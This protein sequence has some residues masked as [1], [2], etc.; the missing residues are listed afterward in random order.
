LNLFIYK[1]GTD[2]PGEQQQNI[3]KK[4]SLNCGQMT[5]GICCNQHDVEEEDISCTV[6]SILAPQKFNQTNFKFNQDH[7][8]LCG[9]A[10]KTIQT[11]LDENLSSRN[12]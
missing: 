7:Y 8:P 11:G 10:S 5:G 4:F 3:Q 1:R 2:D 6:T 12:F 9:G